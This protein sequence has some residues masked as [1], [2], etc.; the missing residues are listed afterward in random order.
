MMNPEKG[1]IL[2]SGKPNTILLKMNMIPDGNW[3]G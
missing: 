1:N 2:N 3:K